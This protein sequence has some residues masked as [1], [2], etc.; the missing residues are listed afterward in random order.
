[1]NKA[2]GIIG[3]GRDIST[4]KR[5]LERILTENFSTAKG[6]LIIVHPGKE[7]FGN[8][9]EKMKEINPNL[10]IVLQDH[11]QGDPDLIFVDNAKKI[12]MI[13]LKNIVRDIEPVVMSKNPMFFSKK[14]LRRDQRY[15]SDRHNF[16][17]SKYKNYRR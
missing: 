2:I 11:N 7:S 4:A 14:D 6:K 10:V 3:M 1:M 16:N 9:I 15:R 8:L 5:Y 17:S 12:E 13:E